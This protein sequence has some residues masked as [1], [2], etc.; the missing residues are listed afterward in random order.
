MMVDLDQLPAQGKMG[1]G[2][3]IRGAGVHHH[4]QRIDISSLGH[5]RI[6][7]PQ[8]GQVLGTVAFRQIDLLF[9]EAETQHPLQPFAGAQTIAVGPL[10]TEKDDMIVFLYFLKNRQHFFPGHFISSASLSRLSSI[11]MAVSRSATV[12]PLAF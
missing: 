12:A 7:R 1:V 8:K 4:A 3:S 11:S 5:S 9:R 6:V 10:V 2:N